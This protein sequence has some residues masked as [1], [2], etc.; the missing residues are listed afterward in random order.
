VTER[1]LLFLILAAYVLLALIYSIIT[2]IFEASDELWHY[3]MVKYLADHGLQLPPQDAGVITAW[4][5]EGSQP[6]LY[7]M[8]A[9][10]L[11]SGIDTS[12]LDVIR[13]QNPHADIGIIRPD[14][15]A[16]M[17]VHHP[18]LESFPWH[19]TTLAIHIVRF[20]SIAL[21]LG[22][23]LVTYQLGCELFPEHP[24]VALGAAALNAFLPMFLFI[25][26]SVNNDNLSNLLGNLL[27]LLIV[28]LLKTA[29]APRWR[30]NAVIGIISGAGLLSKLNIGF[31][32]PLVALAL[33]VVSLRCRDW[34]P[35][36]IG[37]L[38]SG[39]LTV[40]IAGWWYLRNS[41]L[42]G[43]PTGLNMFL[44]FVGRRSPPANLA[45][46]WSERDSF[47]W[48]FWGFF[49]GVNVPLPNPDYV[50]FNVIG[51]SGLVGAVAFLIYTLARRTWPLERWLLAAV[52]L[53]WP[54]ITFVSFLRWT[55]ETPASQGRLIFGA[56]SSILVWL[57][58]GLTWWLPGRI[59]RSAT[60]VVA[61]YFAAIAILAPFSAITPAYATPT[62]I[63]RAVLDSGAD[64]KPI[65]VRFLEPN[66]RSSI[67]LFYYPGVLTGSAQPEDY[68]RL[69]TTWM[70]DSPLKTD[71]S[72]FV[73]LVTPDSVIVG[74]RDV[75]PGQ[76]RLATSDLP[77]GFIWTN[78]IAVWIPPA[79]YAPM[80]LDVII[81]WYDLKTG[82]RMTLADGGTELKIGQVYLN[83]RP[84]NL[85]VP[86]PI[87]INFDNQIELVGYSLSD[88]SLDAGAST[89]LTLYWRALRTPD[90]NYTTFAH[91]LDPRPE[92]LAK[93]AASDSW[94]GGQPTSTWQPGQIIEDQRTLN[95]DPNAPPGI[96]EL[97]IG[98]YH[99]ADDGSFPR[100]RVVSA[101]GGMAFDYAYLSRVRI[102]P[103]E[104]MPQATEAQ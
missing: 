75:Y 54:V 49:G 100:L 2:P 76:G 28:R 52:T 36:V 89:T 99:Q 33:L 30:D 17:V 82:E 78:P 72:L 20:F 73:H 26:G 18:A 85:N 29:Q 34:R 19:G 70:I 46:L 47:A 81:G 40:A 87:S 67:T 42:Y 61:L 56:L 53:L 35:L 98:I 66:T 83:Q 12:D 16:N 77:A 38:I 23:V 96:Y 94:P 65:Q 1:R 45:Q 11:T 79:A 80:P 37:G 13:R 5:Q 74:Q 60:V 95:V 39:A 104:L 57:V 62:P 15:N 69:N 59:R 68:A 10:L 22:T 93:Y 4:R 101:D 48:A 103:A 90:Q 14:G 97:E 7:Y 86:N 9:A 3:P 51:V 24:Y 58:V 63:D 21:G 55:A 88:L 31:L 64:P 25:S 44:S 102:M 84:S 91:I 71:W 6:P 27:T 8:M 50:A 92:S 32:I 43:D 41:Q